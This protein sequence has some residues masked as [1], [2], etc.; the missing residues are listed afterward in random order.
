MNTKDEAH[1]VDERIGSA[2]LNASQ[3]VGRELPFLLVLAGTPELRA[4][5]GALNATFWNRAERCPVG[6]L[7]P[8]A[9]AAA[10]RKPLEDEHVA[11]HEDATVRACPG[12]VAGFGAVMFTCPGTTGATSR[13]H[14]G[15]FRGRR[16]AADSDRG[17]Q[18]LGIG[19][20]T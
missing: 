12:C 11:I 19:T 10:L 3:Q 8:E 17:G 5:L 7:D 6:R 14:V 4:R 9:S 16:A 1:T 20:I 18:C 13:G 2:L 15:A